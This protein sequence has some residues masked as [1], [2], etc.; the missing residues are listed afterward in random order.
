MARG[1]LVNNLALRDLGSNL[2]RRPLTEGPPGLCRGFASQRHDLADWLVGNAP[3]L[4]GPRR[5]R[6]ALCDPE[7]VQGDGLQPQ[8]PGPPQA[9]RIDRDAFLAG[10]LAIVGPLCRSKNHACPQR[11]VLG[12]AVAPH[13]WLQVLPFCL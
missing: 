9:H 7:V 8:P 10:N 5:I 4:A 2:A 3:G 12:G 1:H 11:D 13:E 6:E